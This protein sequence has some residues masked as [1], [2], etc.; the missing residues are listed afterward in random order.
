MARIS[1]NVNSSASQSS[2]EK[3]Q[4]GPEHFDNEK[5]DPDSPNHKVSGLQQATGLVATQEEE[6]AVFRKIDWRLLPFVFVLYT[7]SVLDR[8]NLGNARLAGLEEA[9][10]LSGWRYNWLG[11]IFYIACKEG[12]SQH[13]Q[14][15]PVLMTS[16]RH[17]LPIPAYGMESLS[18]THLLRLC[19]LLLGRY[20]HSSSSSDELGRP[21]GL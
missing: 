16:F 18:T 7:L 3:T 12:S 4:I 20:R 19:G 2:G 6:D 11:T 17:L 13:Q 10:D 1:N 9:I 21:H 5:Y 14:Y 15:F 8:S